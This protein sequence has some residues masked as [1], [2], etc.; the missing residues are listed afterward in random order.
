MIGKEEKEGNCI[1]GK[2]K[3]HIFSWQDGSGVRTHADDTY[4]LGVAE[5]EGFLVWGQPILHSEALSKKYINGKLYAIIFLLAS[6]GQYKKKVL[7]KDNVVTTLSNLI[8]YNINLIW[9][10]KVDINIRDNWD[11]II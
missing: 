1:G 7:Y 4:N 10:L 9:R 6:P 5:A 11:Y 2:R 8:A 3:I